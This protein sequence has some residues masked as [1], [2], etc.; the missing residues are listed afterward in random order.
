MPEKETFAEIDIL[1]DLG[2]EGLREAWRARLGGSAPSASSIGLLRRWLSWEL[3]AWTEGGFDPATRRQ[4]RDLGRAKKG[5]SRLPR[6]SNLRP[7]TILTRE[8]AGKTHRVMVLERGYAW[9]GGQYASLT[10]IAYR[11]TGT[12][13][14]GPR[15][16]G[17]KYKE[18][19]S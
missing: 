11:I 16:F 2:L 17:L 12:R 19:G 9:D 14:S 13:W 18:R 7:G 1:G 6:T 4:L 5:D 3:Q 10:E 8:H 15:F